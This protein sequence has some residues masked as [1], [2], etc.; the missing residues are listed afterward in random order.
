MRYHETLTDAIGQSAVPLSTLQTPKD[1]LLHCVSRSAVKPPAQAA[2]I[3]HLRSKDLLG[4]INRV[5]L[6]LLH[7]QRLEEMVFGLLELDALHVDQTELVL[8]LEI[9][10]VE[11]LDDRVTLLSGRQYRHHLGHEGAALVGALEEGGVLDI[12]EGFSKAS[13]SVE[14]NLE[15]V[16]PFVALE[17][18]SGKGKLLF[19]KLIFDQQSLQSHQ[20][21]GRFL[22]SKRDLTRPFWYTVTSG[23]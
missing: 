19:G 4:V 5:E 15:V 7:G 16:M 3:L 10:T 23:F 2:L 8:D 11:A 12:R 14:K 9:K 18:V 1:L 6:A 22:I 20:H 13:V 21:I 17:I